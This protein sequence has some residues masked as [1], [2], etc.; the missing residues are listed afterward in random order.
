[1][2]IFVVSTLAYYLGYYAIELP[3]YAVMGSSLGAPIP[4]ALNR[5][6]LIP[7]YGVLFTTLSVIFYTALYHRLVAARGSRGEI[8]AQVF[9]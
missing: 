3:L 1:M 9:D 7:L 6:L 5:Y 4:M 2:S 8:T